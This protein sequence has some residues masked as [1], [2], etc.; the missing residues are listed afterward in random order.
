M[1]IVEEEEMMTLRALWGAE[2]AKLW[3]C[4]VGKL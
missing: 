1:M 3:K 4:V 2:D